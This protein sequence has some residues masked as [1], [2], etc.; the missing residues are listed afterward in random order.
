MAASAT[1]RN[2]II[3]GTYKVGEEAVYIIQSGESFAINDSSDN[4]IAAF[5]D[6]ETFI[7]HGSSGLVVRLYTSGGVNQLKIQGLTQ[8]ADDAAASA[9]GVLVGS[10]Y[11][12]SGTGAITQRLV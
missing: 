1:P 9:G 7:S 10:T 3:R 4:V 6:T 12:N 11:I 5:S 2:K 8:Y